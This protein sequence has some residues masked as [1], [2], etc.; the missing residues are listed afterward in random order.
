MNYIDR[1]TNQYPLTRHEVI[2]RNL[3]AGL[4][5]NW[6]LEELELLNVWPVY[7]TTPDLV[8]AVNQ[9][10]VES[11]PLYNTTDNKYHQTWVLV[12]LTPEELEQKIADQWAYVR[13]SRNQMLAHADA[14]VLPDLWERYTPEQKQIWSDYRQALRD[15]P[16]DNADPFA[17]VWPEHPVF[18]PGQMTGLG[19]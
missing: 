6:G 14:M 1:T 11:T 10:V 2:P 18:K 5:N 9:K 8:P 7:P 16:T 19:A 13:K 12:E 4:K 17:I 15:I 3:T